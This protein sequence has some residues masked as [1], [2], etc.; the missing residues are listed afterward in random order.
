MGTPYNFSVGTPILPGAEIKGISARDIDFGNKKLTF[1]ICD[2]SNY[3]FYFTDSVK[4]DKIYETI[5]KTKNVVNLE[6]DITLDI[7]VT[8]SSFFI[9]NCLQ[10][11]RK[12]TNKIKTYLLYMIYYISE[13]YFLPNILILFLSVN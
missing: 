7:C 1:T 9:F 11:S 10:T 8:V 5:L 3:G 12:P 6:D 4:K 13:L 2:N